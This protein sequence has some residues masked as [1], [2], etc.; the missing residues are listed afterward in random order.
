MAAT[1]TPP[2]R[3]RTTA[4]D[5]VY[6]ALKRD[7][8]TL[9]LAP[10]AALTEQQLA[11]SH[12][13]SR[14]PVREACRRLQQEGL[15]TAI[16]YKGYFVSQISL[17]EIE[18]CFD[19]RASLEAFA[20]ERAVER[21]SAADLAGLA[22]LARTE[23]TYDD[24]ASYAEFLERNLEFHL[25]LAQLTGNGRLVHTLHDLVESMQRFFFLG[26]DLGDYGGEMR[27]EHEELVELM[28]ARSAERAVGCMRDQIA[29]SRERVLRA[30]LQGRVELPIR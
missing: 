23:Y 7:I 27:S 15:L 26:L 11:R 17:K 8:I 6:G 1:S 5:T 28:A 29:A 18:D 14:V 30:V 21:A 3:E 9:R 25:R 16:P 13:T 4:S 24:R 19:L 12:R 20:V 22:E 10:G 2:A